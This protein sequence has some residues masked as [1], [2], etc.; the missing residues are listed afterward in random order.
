MVYPVKT[1][2]VTC[3]DGVYDWGIAEY[4]DYNYSCYVAE[5]NNGEWSCATYGLGTIKSRL[6]PKPAI[7]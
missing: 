5:A 2:F 7:K 3:D 4:Q 6:I 1:T